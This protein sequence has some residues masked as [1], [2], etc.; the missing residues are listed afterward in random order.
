VKEPILNQAEQIRTKEFYR[1]KYRKEFA[2]EDKPKGIRIV[3]PGTV[4]AWNRKF[5][6][7]S[8]GLDKGATDRITS[9]ASFIKRLASAPW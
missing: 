9:R 5:P 8:E 1:A 4:I 2:T 3:K 7:F 6:S